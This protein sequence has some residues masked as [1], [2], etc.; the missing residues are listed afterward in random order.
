MLAPT[1]REAATGVIAGFALPAAAA[2]PR[3]IV[4][5]NPCLDAIL[6][7]VADRAQ[8][9]AVSH[10]THK[11]ETSSS[12]E[13]GLTYPFTYESAEEVIA[14]RPDLVLSSTYTAA[15]TRSALTRLHIRTELFGLPNSVADSVAQVRRVAAL[16]GRPQ[17]GEA[18]VSRIEAS[19]AAAAPPPGA[20]RPSALVFQ[21]GGFAVSKGTLV[22]ELLRRAGFDNAASRYGLLR[23]GSVPLERLIADPPDVLLCGQ[24]KPGAP[25]W[26]DRV[27]RHPALSAVAGRMMRT[28]FPQR[29]TFCGGPVIVEAAAMLASARRAALDHRG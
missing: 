4:S 28:D 24:P 21:S 13:A 2:A 16:A 19:I 7:Q 9:A 17:R 5:L 3:R 26:A 6:I 14:L 23:T 29:L 12:G 22:D 18:L 27:L 11:P 8:V 15:A 20:R 1:R 25:T 10:Y